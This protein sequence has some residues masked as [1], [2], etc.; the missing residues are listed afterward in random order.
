MDKHNND[1]TEADS[2]LSMSAGSLPT[3]YA[4]R[5]LEEIGKHYLRHLNAMT[6]E[7]LQSKSD[8]AAELA[9]RDAIIEEL[10]AENPQMCNEGE[11]NI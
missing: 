7:N 10:K 9:V 11:P 8:I 3:M 4:K 6:A 2:D 5:D 1:K